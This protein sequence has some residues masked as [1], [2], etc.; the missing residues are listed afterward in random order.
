M[1]GDAMER[2][3]ISDLKNLIDKR[4]N[5]SISIYI[6]THKEWNNSDQNLIRFKNH[7]QQIEKELSERDLRD[8]QISDILKPAR[9]LMEEKSF[10]MHQSLGLAAFI[11]SNEFIHYRLPIELK[12]MHYISNRFC[13]KPILPYFYVNGSFFI[14]ALDLNECKLYKASRYDIVR[15]TLPES[16]PLG[17]PEEL[18]NYEFQKTQLHPGTSGRQKTQTMIPGTFHGH[19]AGGLDER[20]RKEKILEFFRELNNGVVKKIGGENFP[21]ILSGVSF[22]IGLYKEA[23]SYPNLF[24]KTL[25]LDPQSLS[26]DELKNRTWKLLEPDFDKKRESA[27]EKYRQFS[28]NHLASSNIDEVVKAAFNKRVESL[29]INPNVF[30]WGRFNPDSDEVIVENSP[31]INNEDLIDFSAFHTLLNKGF[32]YAC[33]QEKMPC[34]K[35]LAAV[36][37]Y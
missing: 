11:S 13:I 31:S 26:E 17:L 25:D 32:I 35:P 20:G 8:K 12:E 28:G 30:I 2:L 7:L 29:F 1:K 15:I 16:T 5:N 4:D 36:F 23:S 34:N 21:L 37:R 18:K 33:E 10:W 24:Q 9:E 14:L 6:P 22:L 3:K 19:G 27:Y